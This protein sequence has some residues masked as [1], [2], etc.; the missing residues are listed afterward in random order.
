MERKSCV[1]PWEVCT[2]ALGLVASRGA[3][4]VVQESAEAVVAISHYGEG[5]NM[6]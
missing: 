5:L 3:A 6:S 2:T 4:M 1:L